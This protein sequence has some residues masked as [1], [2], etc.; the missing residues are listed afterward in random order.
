MNPALGDVGFDWAQRFDNAAR[1]L[2]SVDPTEVARLD[3]NQDYEYAVP[4]PDHFI[5]LLYLAGLAGAQ[6]LHPQVGA[7]GVHPDLPIPEELEGF[8]AAR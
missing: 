2:M 8:L 4:T 6:D 5:P 1:E 3:A 7:L